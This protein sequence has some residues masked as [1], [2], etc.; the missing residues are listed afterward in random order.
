MA[1]ITPRQ[2]VKDFENM[3]LEKWSQYEHITIAI[4]YAMSSNNPIELM[5]YI[6]CAFIRRGVVMNPTSTSKDCTERWNESKSWF[7][8][9]IC[10]NLVKQNPTLILSKLVTLAHKKG[11]MDKNYIYQ[12]YEADFIDNTICRSI[13]SIEIKKES[14]T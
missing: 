11:Y 7:W 4:H 1:K 6:R 13:I 10:F 14:F 9:N 3:R 5:G 8:V 12:F 2:I